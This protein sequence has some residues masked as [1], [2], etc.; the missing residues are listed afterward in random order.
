MAKRLSSLFSSKDGEPPRSMSPPQLNTSLTPPQTPSRGKLTKPMTK[1]PADLHLNTRLS[2]D[3]EP[4]PAFG[5]ERVSSRPG[6]RDGR[7]PLRGDTAGSRQSSGSRPQTPTLLSVPTTA[8]PARDLSPSSRKV[9]KRRSWIGGKSDKQST[10]HGSERPRTQAWIAGLRELVPY[11]ITNLLNG[12][13]VR[14][15]LYSFEER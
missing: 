2:F 10:E 8:S 3:L 14:R 12:E 4:P 6:S 1:S 5:D 9:N 11:D 15:H 7:T 13:P